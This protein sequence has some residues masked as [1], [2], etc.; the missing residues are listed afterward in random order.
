LLLATWRGVIA[1]S[2]KNVFFTFL[3][4]VVEA[5]EPIAEGVE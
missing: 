3:L 1:F 5:I 4:L 2:T